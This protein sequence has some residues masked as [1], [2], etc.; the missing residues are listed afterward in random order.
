MYV[1]DL[2]LFGTFSNVFLDN[3]QLFLCLAIVGEVEDEQNLIY[4][5]K[6]F[7]IGYNDN[8]VYF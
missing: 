5:H 8:R 7:E 3:F 4:T 1:D 2:P 6:K